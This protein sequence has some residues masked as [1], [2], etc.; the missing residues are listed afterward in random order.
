MENTSNIENTSNTNISEEMKKAYNHTGMFITLLMV[1]SYAIIFTARY[2]L[3][4]S[5]S[6]LLSDTGFVLIL[7][8]VP[9]YIS[10]ILYFFLMKRPPAK[11]ASH[12]SLSKKQLVILYFI[13]EACLTIGNLI[14]VVFGLIVNLIF[15]V[16]SANTTMQLLEKTNLLVLFIIAI[17]VGPIFEELIFRKF[18]LDKVGGYVPGAAIIM[19]GLLFGLFHQNLYQ[20]FYATALGCIFAFLYISTGKN[21]INTLFH[22]A[23]N[24]IHSF[25]PIVLMSH[26][27][28]N[29]LMNMGDTSQLLSEAT[30]DPNAVMETLSTIYTPWFILFM[31]YS[32]IVF[33]VAIV[34]VIL[35]VVHFKLIKSLIP[36][37][38]TDTK[39][40]LK[41]ILTRP[42]IIICIVFYLALTVISM[43][44]S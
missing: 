33:I 3:T 6:N 10:A 35:F 4:K 16:Q 36:K 32:F 17:L 29:A 40:A 19:S 26:I 28:L 14:G 31:I 2:F 22:I 12:V 23:I 38:F 9:T 41:Q 11:P 8:T 43:V 25:I 39:T 42:F 20:F 5:G 1:I 18:L 30:T 37:G 27:D 21:T 34:G 24:F 44:I 13:C 7:G 15:K